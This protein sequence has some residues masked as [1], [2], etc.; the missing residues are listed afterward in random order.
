MWTYQTPWKFV[1]VLWVSCPIPWSFC[2]SLQL[3]MTGTEPRKGNSGNCHHA[4]SQQSKYWEISLKPWTWET[5]PHW[6]QC[7]SYTCWRLQHSTLR[8][9]YPA[10][11]P[12]ASTYQTLGG[13]TVCAQSAIMFSIN[14]AELG[15][16]VKHSHIILV[17]SLVLTGNMWKSRFWSDVNGMC[18]GIAVEVRKCFH[19]TVQHLQMYTKSDGELLAYTVAR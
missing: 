16:G 14:S 17:E 5:T 8:A 9:K 18:T 1:P 7:S 2:E 10:L 19:N 3:N 15:V 6:R 12:N 11:A 4:K 13:G